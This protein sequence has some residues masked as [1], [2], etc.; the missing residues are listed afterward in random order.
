LNTLTFG[1]TDLYI[2][3]DIGHDENNQP[4]PNSVRLTIAALPEH[5]PFCIID[6]RQATVDVFN[7]LPKFGVN[8]AS[9]VI[10]APAKVEIIGDV[11]HLYDP[12]QS[13]EEYALSISNETQI[14]LHDFIYIN[15]YASTKPGIPVTIFVITLSQ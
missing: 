11:V 8:R 15:H 9:G 5:S 2:F 14:P 3:T 7:H 6:H 13:G 12:D 1:V 10:H 4:D